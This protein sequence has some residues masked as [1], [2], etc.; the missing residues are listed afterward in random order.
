MRHLKIFT[1]EKRGDILI[2]TPHGEGSAFRYQ[3]LHMETNAIRQY[4]MKPDNKHLIMDLG[5]LTYFGSE[6]IGSLVSIM[7]ETRSRRGIACF[8]SANEQMHQVLRNMSLFKLWPHYDSL[9]EA[10]ASYESVE[11]S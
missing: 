9:A 2:V 10:L 3:D 8:C 5:E 11:N 6:F 7:R 1:T 4:M